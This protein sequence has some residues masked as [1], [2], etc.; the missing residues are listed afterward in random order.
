MTLFEKDHVVGV[1]RGFSEGGMEF[2]ADI[3][4]PYRDDFQ[5]LPMHGQFV[6]VQLEHEHEAVF[7][8]ITSIASQGRL[9]SPIGEDYAVRAVRDQRPIPDELRD[10]YLKYK[11]DIRVLGVLRKDGAKLIFVPSHRRLPHVGAQVAFLSPQLLAEVANANDTTEDAVAIGFLAFGE[12]VYSGG[13]ERASAEPW[14]VTLSPAVMPRFQISKLVA[15]RSF[16][17]ARAGFG[18]SNLVKL[19]FS[20]LYSIEPTVPRRNGIKVPVGTVIFDPDGEYFWPDHQG[21]PGLCDVPELRDRLVV[22]TNR[23][24]PSKAYASFVVDKVKLD[25]RQLPASRVVGLTIPGEKQEQQNVVKLKNLKDERWRELVNIIY[26]DWYDANPA[27]VAELLGIKADRSEQNMELTAAI[28]N[29]A[30]I[31]RDHHDPSSQL[32][33][34]LKAALAKGMLCVVDISQMRGLQGLQLAGIILA[35]IFD[36]NQK[37]FTEA[38]PQTIPTIAVLEEA[39]SILGAAGNRDDGPFVAWV[40]EGRKYDLGAMMITQQPGSIPSEL[41]SQGDNF[42]V[43]HLLA[44]GDLTALKRA[45]AHFSGD[46]LAALLN[47]PL[48]GHGVFWSSAPGTDEHARPYPL[49]VRVLDFNKTVGQ[50]LGDAHPGEPIDNYAAKLRATFAA[51]A[52]QAPA[53]DAG[54]DDALDGQEPVDV[55]E[56]YRAEAIGKLRTDPT[57]RR[58]MSSGGYWWGDIQRLLAEYAPSEEIVGKGQRFTWAY[59]VMTQALNEIFGPQGPQGWD[60]EPRDKGGFTRK[61]VVPTTQWPARTASASTHDEP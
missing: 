51:A 13:D 35:D 38:D 14:M 16:V 12:F 41:V 30:K 22:F 23:K 33:R 21:R 25:I 2:H 42:F 8:R 37:Q 36:H 61:W 18:K 44:E 20:K 34:A 45:N 1:F 39:Q 10:Q 11:V 47:E 19:L 32:L 9:T 50:L 55:E 15:R 26:R 49:S 57:F 52:H 24:A 17:F 28:S 43:F 3:V 46:L 56:R 60:T 4:M 7:G 58:W 40:K 53:R 54:A 31:V 59:P 48:V 6:L 27:R 5:S 29:M